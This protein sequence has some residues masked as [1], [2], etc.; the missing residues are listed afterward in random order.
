MGFKEFEIHI[1]V[2]M[3]VTIQGI[4]GVSVLGM[5]KEFNVLE[6]QRPSQAMGKRKGMFYLFGVSS[7]KAG[8]L[9][10]AFWVDCLM[11]LL[12][13]LFSSICSL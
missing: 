8:S 13:P 6:G 7:L 4:F 12:G 2:S 1:L 5:D 3:L 9:Q 11:G 10:N